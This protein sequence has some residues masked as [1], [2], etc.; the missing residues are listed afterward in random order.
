[1]PNL[2]SITLAAAVLSTTLPAICAMAQISDSEAQ[3]APRI[4]VMRRHGLAG[5]VTSITGS[6]LVMQIP[7]NVPFTIQTGPS[8]RFTSLGQDAIPETSATRFS[9]AAT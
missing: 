2:Q 6:Q 8:T 7:E 5:V 9:P 1:L 4:G 3:P